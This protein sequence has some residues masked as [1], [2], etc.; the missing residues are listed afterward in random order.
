MGPT[1]LISTESMA[2]C[3]QTLLFCFQFEAFHLN[4][5]NYITT[6]SYYQNFVLGITFAVSLRDENNCN[7]YPCDTGSRESPGHA[8]R[9]VVDQGDIH[10]T[11]VTLQKLKAWN[12]WNMEVMLQC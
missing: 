4:T 1:L 7:H 3:W 10:L 12:N 5:K 6:Y 8:A 9:V 11:R 2:S